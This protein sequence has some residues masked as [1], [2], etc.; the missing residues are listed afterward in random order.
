MRRAD[1]LFAYLN[2]NGIAE[3]RDVL[4]LAASHGRCRRAELVE[5]LSGTVPVRRFRTRYER[6]ALRN[7]ATLLADQ[8]EGPT[9]ADDAIVLVRALIDGVGVRDAGK[10]A[11]FRLI[12]MIVERSETEEDLDEFIDT[13]HIARDDAA[14]QHLLRANAVNPFSGGRS[15]EPWQAHVNTM[16]ASD[17]LDTITLRPGEDDP[18]D[19]VSSV[20]AQTRGDGPLVTVIIPTYEPGS[21]LATAVESLLAQSHRSLQILIVDDASSPETAASLDAWRE[22]DPRIEIVHLPENA[23]PYLARNIAVSEYTRGAY[24]TVHDDDDWSHP[25]KIERQVDHLEQNPDEVAN[26]V[27]AVRASDDMQFGRINGNPVWTQHAL[28]SLMVRR[29]AFDVIGFWDVLNRSADAEFNDRIRAWTARRI[30]VVGRVPH[31]FYRVRW[32][33]LS[34]GEFHHGYM[35]ARRRWYRDSYSRWHA[36][37][38][39]AGRAPHLPVDDRSTRPFSVPADLCGSR[40]GGERSVAVDVLF[41]GD[42]RDDALDTGGIRARI[43]GGA[44][45]ALLQVDSPRLAPSARVRADIL[46]LARDPRVSIFSLKDD[47]IAAETIVLDT[48]I[49]R[50]H[51][52]A[53]R[54]LE[55]HV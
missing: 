32:D 43:A 40:Q 23:G 38:I 42:F 34:A 48:E 8:P 9:D 54:A 50:F 13:L 53:R 49:L 52:E 21:R 22:R 37:E 10:E 55:A 17:G 51:A 14:Q 7:L 5:A 18:F 41:A 35:D 1:E 4:A 31:A 44:N 11:R 6:T 12:E 30:P 39:V 15:I 25:R 33:S 26:M 2:V 45:V 28:S 20:P 29:S 46:D 19:R 27:N 47:V 36:S 24:V 16:L 3:G